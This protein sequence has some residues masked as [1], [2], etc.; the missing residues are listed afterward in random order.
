MTDALQAPW[1]RGT[2]GEWYVVAQV[3]FIALVA[4]GPRTLP[5]LP[6]FPL[7]NAALLAGAGLTLAGGCLFL[8]GLLALGRN[9]TPVPAPKP[10]ATLVR[11]GPYRL[12]RHPM[13]AGG[14]LVCYGW[15]LLAQGWFTLA[16]ASFAFVFMD[17]K[18]S[19]EE[20]WLVEKYPSYVDY[21]RRVRKLIPFVY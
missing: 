13:Y 11:N 1:W 4:F 14:L 20:R 6:A 2:R 18:A 8:A 5:S 3:G 10:G 19:R 16:Y 12:V 9:L 21:Q 17:L 15:A 7:P